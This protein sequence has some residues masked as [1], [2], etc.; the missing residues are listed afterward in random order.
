[1]NV[2]DDPDFVA[3][4][5]D[6]RDNMVPRMINSALV[7]SLY[8]QSF[9]VK[10][11]VELGAALMMD[12]PVILSVEPGVQVPDKLVS[13]ADEIVEYD[14]SHPDRYQTALHAAM[15]RVLEAR[16]LI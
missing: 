2:F 10:F 7:V 13:A 12:K 14:R 9:D 4:A 8:P 1:M 5:K 15:T 16:G 6:V 11:A 3:W